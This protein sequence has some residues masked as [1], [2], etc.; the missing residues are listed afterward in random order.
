MAGVFHKQAAVNI[1]LT[2]R[3]TIMCPVIPLSLVMEDYKGT[4]T[5]L[6]YI[7]EDNLWIIRDF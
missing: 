4:P 6:R 7:A 3:K 5:P 1:L 2:S